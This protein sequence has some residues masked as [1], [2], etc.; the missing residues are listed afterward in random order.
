MRR[1]DAPNGLLQPAL[2]IVSVGFKLYIEEP[3]K[4]FHSVGFSFPSITKIPGTARV[5]I[6]NKNNNLII[7]YFIIYTY[8]FIFLTRILA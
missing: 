3:G 8:N 5:P 6:L 4:I 2:S 1:I 7:F